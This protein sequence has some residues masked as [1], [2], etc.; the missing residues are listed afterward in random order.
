MPTFGSGTSTPIVVPASAGLP[1][2][3]QP[4]TLLSLTRFS[5][6]LQYSPML[7]NQVHVANLQPGGACSDPIMQYT[8][9]PMSGGRPGREEIAHAIKQAEDM[10]ETEL[11][12]PPAPRWIAADDVNTV[13]FR[14]SRLRGASNRSV[15]RS[16]SYHVIEGGR[17]AW[18]LLEDSL[19]TWSDTDLD[20]YKG[21]G[22]VVVATTITNPD[23]IAVY[24]PGSNRDPG[25]EIRPIQVTISGGFATVRFARHL[26]VKPELLES[27]HPRYRLQHWHPTFQGAQAS[28]PGDEQAERSQTRQI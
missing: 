22:T 6:I 18:Q 9:Q 25:W 15:V 28:R 17:E 4:R 2:R 7:F 12:F 26:V 21:T 20:G 3:T 1:T 5:Q 19:I 27:C 16:H 24:Y 13:S 11:K 23:E 8:W 14:S 10:I